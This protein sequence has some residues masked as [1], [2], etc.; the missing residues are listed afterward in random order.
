MDNYHIFDFEGGI[1]IWIYNV[2]SVK[3]LTEN[4]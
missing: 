4:I 1:K 2:L 3:W